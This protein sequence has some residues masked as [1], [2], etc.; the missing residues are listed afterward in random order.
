VADNATMKKWYD[1]AKWLRRFKWDNHSN[2]DYGPQEPE[3]ETVAHLDQADIYSSEI[4]G[5]EKMQ[6]DPFSQARMVYRHMVALDLDI[7]AV[8]VPSS[9]EGHH[10]LLIDVDLSEHDYMGLLKHLGELGIIEKG[11]AEICTKRKA[12]HLRAPWRS[13]YDDVVPREPS[14]EQTIFRNQ[15]KTRQVEDELL[16]PNAVHPPRPDQTKIPFELLEGNGSGATIG[17][18]HPMEEKTDATAQHPF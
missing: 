16:N 8:L 2:H 1:I 3:L 7:P 11:Y 9:T 10:H 14:L 12:S 18:N 4:K 15:V 17:Y 13:K 6:T 5:S